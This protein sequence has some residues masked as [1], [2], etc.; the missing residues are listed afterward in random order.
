[1][2]VAVAG[3][4][5]ERVAPGIDGAAT[6]EVAAGG[7]LLS[8]P[9]VESHVH[10]DTT[11][12]AGQPRWNG[13]G[14]LF[15]GIQ[16]WTERK[17]E[18]S[19]RDVIERAT[20]L[21]RWQAAQGVLHVRT[22]A[23]TTDPELTGLKALLELR[24]KVRSWIDVQVVAFPQEGLLSYPKGAELMEE[25]MKLGAD[26]VGG[27]PHFEHTREM[28]AASVK[29]TFR[30]AEKYDRPIDVHCDETDDPESRFLEVMA[31]EAIRT[32]MGGRVTA[33]HTTAFG[34][35]DNAYAFKLMGFLVK[36]GI[37]F[38]AN[39]LI[40]ITLQGRYDAYPKRRGITRVKELLQNGLNVSLGYDDVM[41]PWYP[42]GTGGMLQPAHMAVHACHMTTRE[43]V[44]ACFD[45]VTEGGARTLGLDGYGL[46]EGSRADFVLVD[47]PEKW[48]AVRRLAATTLVVKNGEVISETRPAETRL[49]GEVVDFGRQET[50]EER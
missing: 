47:A 32:G 43:E 40:N 29:E 1:M 14:T 8:P 33:S 11:L 5:I 26:A 18:I 35:Y 25:A 21:L 30:L 2:D 41:D 50:T 38:V 34:S 49:M 6:R 12:T 44:V 7:R 27:I 3:G 22:H 36:S 24:E 15:E 9:F 13:S 23:D 17:E 10:L 37:N 39:P 20:R 42:L 31:A 48:E 16:I 45:M 28:G 46:T 4:R 19:H